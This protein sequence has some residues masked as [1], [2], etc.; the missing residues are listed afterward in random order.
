[1]C[2]GS[3]ALHSPCHQQTVTLPC[4]RQSGESERGLT[5]SLGSPQLHWDAVEVLLDDP[6]TFPLISPWGSHVQLSRDMFTRLVRQSRAGVPARPRGI[7]L[8]GAPMCALKLHG[9]VPGS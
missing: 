7:G 3:L 1:M 9:G 6:D 8:I 2:K 5:L 4:R